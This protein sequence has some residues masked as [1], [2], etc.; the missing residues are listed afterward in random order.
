MGKIES[1]K[2]VI[3]QNKEYKNIVGFGF[4][5]GDKVHW[6]RERMCKSCELSNQVRKVAE[7]NFHKPIYAKESDFL[8]SA[9]SS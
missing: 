8:H 6:N 5:I 1:P 2:C 7:D 9:N 3:C 4:I